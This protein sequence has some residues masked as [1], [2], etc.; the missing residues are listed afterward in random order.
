MRKK[1]KQAS[2]QASKQGFGT[3]LK[4]RSRPVQPSSL[5]R[6]ARMM[7]QIIC[8]KMSKSDGTAKDL[9]IVDADPYIAEAQKAGGD[10]ALTS[11]VVFVAVTY[12]GGKKREDL[13]CSLC[14]AKIGGG[15]THYKDF[16]KDHLGSTGHLKIAN[17]YDHK[18][19]VGAFPKGSTEYQTYDDYIEAFVAPREDAMRDH[20]RHCEELKAAFDKDQAETRAWWEEKTKREEE[21]EKKRARTSSS[22]STKV[23]KAQAQA[24]IIEVRKYQGS[25][26]AYDGAVETLKKFVNE[27]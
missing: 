11:G 17:W 6:V 18:E 21:A 13:K 8:A 4:N 25:D 2:K 1:S 12:E 23:T 27:N 22:S 16:S 5:A 24:A 14:P 3:W 19:H 20:V 15:V 26:V 9:E 10:T 7:A